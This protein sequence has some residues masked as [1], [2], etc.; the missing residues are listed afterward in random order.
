[1]YDCYKCGK[2]YSLE[3]IIQR[4]PHSFGFVCAECWVIY[5]PDE[6]DSYIKRMPPNEGKRFEII[7]TQLRNKKIDKINERRS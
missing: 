4:Q 2:R 3:K 1:M 7:K 5:H 6:V